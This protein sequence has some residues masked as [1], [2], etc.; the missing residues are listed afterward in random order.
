MCTMKCDKARDL[1]S[2]I[3]IYLDLRSLTKIQSDGGANFGD[4]EKLLLS[5]LSADRQ[6]LFH[7]SAAAKPQSRINT[8]ILETAKGN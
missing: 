6:L 7:D 4:F 5:F 3:W 2:W 8:G 1:R